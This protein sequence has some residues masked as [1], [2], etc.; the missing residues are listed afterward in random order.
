MFRSMNSAMIPSDPSLCESPHSSPCGPQ[1][2]VAGQDRSHDF[3]AELSKEGETLGS[4][5]FRKWFAEESA[6]L[7]LGNA[8]NE[9]E[10]QDRQFAIFGVRTQLSLSK[11]ELPTTAGAVGKL[12]NLIRSLLWRVTRHPHD[13]T[14]FHQNNINEQVIRTLEH[15]VRLRRREA[16]ELRERL[17]ALEGRVAQSESISS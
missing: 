10:F 12:V 1:V 4:P 11:F 15:E 9:T 3:G 14:I 7:E 5:A 17:A 8:Q 2:L 13:W 16:T 6:V